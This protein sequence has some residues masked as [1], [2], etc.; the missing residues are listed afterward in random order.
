LKTNLITLGAIL[1]CGT[2]HADLAHRFVD[3]LSPEETK[4]YRANLFIETYLTDKPSGHQLERIRPYGKNGKW[5]RVLAFNFGR[6]DAESAQAY[7][8]KL[9]WEALNDAKAKP[10][11]GKL[12]GRPTTTGFWSVV[13]LSKPGAVTIRLTTRS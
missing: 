10:K 11:F 13:S 1:M 12:L 6:E 7:G 5:D 4:Y 3:E 8:R 9:F 2:A